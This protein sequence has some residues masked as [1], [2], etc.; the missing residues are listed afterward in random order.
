MNHTMS[1]IL[2]SSMVLQLVSAKRSSEVQFVLDTQ[3]VLSPGVTAAKVFTHGSLLQADR[4]TAFENHTSPTAPG[5]ARMIVL[6]FGAPGAGKGS[7]APAIQKMLGIP[8][9]STGDMLREEMEKEKE[10][11]DDDAKTRPI[12]YKMKEGKLVDMETVQAL[13]VKRIAKENED[14]KTGFMLDGFPRDADQAKWLVKTLQEKGEKVS[15]VLDF[16]VPFEVLEERICGRWQSPSGRSYHQKFKQPLSYKE[17]LEKD[18]DA[19][20]SK[21][22]MKDDEDK[23]Q[24]TQRQ[25]DHPEALEKRLAVFE[26]QT[27]PILKYL[28][29]EKTPL[30]KI[31]AAAAMQA[32]CKQV[33]KVLSDTFPSQLSKDSLDEVVK[34]NCPEQNDA[35]KAEATEADYVKVSKQIDS[36]NK[37]INGSNG[38][39]SATA[40]LLAMLVHMLS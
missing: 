24:L 30:V 9:L 34:Q 16:D 15:L 36:D 8:Q 10:L 12:T 38:F 14:V 6:L 3:S 35:E 5:N 22:N 13:V 31:E 4:T 20:P 39:L 18:K 25:D 7:H 32:I 17:A 26:K 1:A 23:S 28:E 37:M 19:K 11:D 40:F 27:V 29:A 21:D 33:S 2:L